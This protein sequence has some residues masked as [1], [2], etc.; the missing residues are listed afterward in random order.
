MSHSFLRPLPRTRRSSNPN[1]NPNPLSSWP[2]A[3]FISTHLSCMMMLRFTSGKRG[4]Q[5][6]APQ[7]DDKPAP[8]A[9]AD[10]ACEDWADL[11]A[12]FPALGRASPIK[13]DPAN[14]P[15]IVIDP[16]TGYASL[17]TVCSVARPEL[18]HAVAERDWMMA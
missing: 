6:A 3:D 2:L 9:P 11:L 8:T 7:P 12:V 16:T 14:V 15:A 17:Q 10:A 13:E 4:F 1:P 18:Y 5:P